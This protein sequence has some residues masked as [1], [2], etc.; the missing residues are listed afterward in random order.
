MAHPLWR[1]INFVSV[2]C[3]SCCYFFVVLKF[4]IKTSC[5]R[6]GRRRCLINNITPLT[7]DPTCWE[8]RLNTCIQIVSNSMQCSSHHTLVSSCNIILLDCLQKSDP[9]TPYPSFL[10]MLLTTTRKSVVFITPCYA[11]SQVCRF[12][13]R[14]GSP[15]SHTNLCLLISSLMNLSFFPLI[16]YFECYM[17]F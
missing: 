10:R 11:N 8:G 7:T 14:C 13:A 12:V 16:L 2:N 17:V 9:S 6:C 3:F 4:Y 15:Y 5:L 1:E